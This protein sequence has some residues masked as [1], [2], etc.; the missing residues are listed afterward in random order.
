M[1]SIQLNHLSTVRLS[2]AEISDF[3]PKS[4]RL[5]VTA[6]NALEVVDVS[7]PNNPIKVDLPI[8][9]SSFGAGIQSVAV[10]K[11]TGTENSIVAVAISAN[12]S[13]DPGKVVFFDAVTLAKISE[14][15]VGSLPDMITF[16][17]DGTK[18]LVANEGEPSE[19]YTIDPESS[20]SIIDVSGDIA[21]LDN[22]KVTTA[23]FT[24]F[25]GQIDDLKAN[26]VRIFGPNATVAQDL[27]PEYIAVSP[28]GQT[29]FI[30][31]QENN[32]VAVLDIANAT[33]TDIL[34]LGF[35]DHNLPGN[36]L[37]ASDED[38]GIN[39]QN[40]PVFGM[41]QPDAISSFEVGGNTYYITANEGD[42]RI[43]PT[44]D[45]ILPAPNNEEGD[46]FNEE[47]RIKGV[48][49]DPTAFPNAAELQADENIGRLNITNT[50]GDT[51]GD[52]D[53]DQL[54]TYGA[55][56]FS[57]WNDQGELV[58]D[59]GDQIAQIIA[60]ETPNLFNANDGS[61]DEFDSRSDNK[62]A[63]PESVTV[64]VIDGTPYAFVG[65]E[66]AGGG[67]MVYNLS[68]P[69]APNFVQYIRTEGDVAPE[70]LKF[71]SASDSPNGKPMLA[72]SNEV[73]NTTSFY[74]IV[75]PKLTTFEF[76][77]LPSL[78]TSATGQEFLLGGFS[79]LY[80]TGVAAN[81]NLT[82]VT[83]PDRGP[84]GDNS[85]AG[86]PFPLPDFQPEIVKFEL[87]QTSGEISITD[88]IGLFRADGTTPLTGLPN[89]QPG[90]QGTAY[91]DEFAID[92]QGN[93]VANDPFGA[94]LEGIVVAPN[95]DF[96]MVDEYRP[97]IYH[98]NSDGVLIH[99]FIATGT[100]AAAGQ[101]E[102]TFGTEVLP[103]V[104]AQRRGNRG[105]EAVALEGNKLYA[106]IQSAIDNPDNAG[107]TT[108]RNSRNLRIVELDI[109]SQ[110]VTG[111]YLYLLKD[112]TAS[113]NAKTDKI[114]DAV[115]LGNG[116]FAVVERDDRSDNTSNKLIYQIDLAAATN[117]HDPGNFTLPEG[118]TIE[119]LSPLE[120][121][122]AGITP[123]SKNL[124]INAAQAGYTG[125]EKLEG[126]ALIAPNTLAVLNDNDFNIIGSANNADGSVT[127]NFSET[128]IPEKLGI[129]ELGN[130][131]P[132]A[133]ITGTSE[134]DKLFEF[135]SGYTVLGLAGDDDIDGVLKGTGNN[136][137]D[138]G[139]G[140]D[141][142]YA[143]ENDIALGGSGN[144]YL[145][146]AD[147]DNNTNN[148]LYGGDGNDEIFPNRH[149]RVF[150]DA[151]DDTILSGNGGNT[152]TGGAG[153]DTFW[154]A[155][156]EYLESPNIITD[157]N[158]DEDSLEVNVG[159]FNAISQLTFTLQ[160]NDTLI[161]AND[162]QLA[163]L[164]GQ[165]YQLPSITLAVNPSSVTENG[166]ANLVYT[167]TR[168][169]STTN[170]L[171][172][173][174]GITG[175]AD[176]NDYTGA[177]PGASKTIT[178]EV[179]SST[180]TLT[181]DPTV[182]TNV[183]GDETVILTLATGTDYTVG[184]TE[185][186]TGTITDEIIPD[187]TPPVITAGQS[188]SY[189]E[190]QAADFTV[191]TVAAT[192]NVGVTGFAISSG[193]DSGFF[194]IDN[195]GVI[196][197]TTAGVAS[198]AN[199]FE[200]T[201][202]SFTLGITATDA[203]GTTSTVTDVIVSVTDVTEIIP[204][205]TAP[206]ITA[207]QTFSYAE[208]QAADF[209]V[210]TV[211]ATDNV[212]VTGFAIAS[213]NDSGLFSIDN[214]GV[215]SLTTAGV[216][217]A[218][219]DFETTPNSFTL[220]VTATDAA[221]TTSTVTDVIVSVTDVN[222]IVPDTTAPVITAGQSFS[223]AENQAA[224]F[225]V[226]TVA[227]TDNVGVTGFAIASG[228][229]SGFFSIDNSGVISLTTAGVASA[230][231]DFETTPNSFTL[232]ITATDAAG[233]TSTVTDVIVS[234]TDVNETVP[235]TT[236]P[237]ITAGQSF[238][239]AENQAADFTV[240]TV[241]A[242]DNVGV[243]GFAIASGNDS[244]LFS[245]DNS[246]VISLTTAGV[247]SAANDFETTPN[248]FTLGVTATDAAGTTST[249]TDVIV[250][251]TDVNET[252]PDTTA[253]VIT[254][255][256]SFSY[257]EN[258]AAD[259]TVGTVAA[260]DNVGVTGFAIASGNDLGLFSIDNSGVISLTTAGVASAAN[261]F[262]TT[263]N[264]FTLGVTATDAAGTNSTVTDVIVS[265]TD[266]NED[267]N[268][269]NNPTL[270]NFTQG[271]QEDETI[272][273]G[274]GDFTDVNKGKFQDQDNDD[275]TAIKVTSLPTSGSLTFVGGQPVT[276]D[277]TIAIDELSQLQYIPVLN[278]NGEVTTF[279]VVAID[280]QGG[281]SAPA[282]VTINLTAVNDAPLAVADQL[283]VSQGGSGR[284]NPLSNDSDPD[285]DNL[286]ITNQTNGKYGQVAKNGNNL[287]Y[288]LLDANFIGTDVFSYTVSDGAL[289]ATTNVAV[290][291]TGK[292]AP[293]TVPPYQL[294]SV[295]PG[296]ALIPN[297]ASNRLT[298]I[299]DILAYRFSNYEQ[300]A[301]QRALQNA[302]NRTNAS[303]NNVFGLYEL[304][305]ETGAVN[306]IKPGQAGYA[307]AAL[308]KVVDNFSARVGGSGNG[309][310]SNVIISGD[311]IYAPFVIANSSSLSGSLQQAIN[312]FFA[313]NPNNNRAT[314]QNYTSLTVAYFSFG[315]ANPDG[316]AHLKSFGNNV[317]GFED[318]PAGV[319]VSDYDFND[320]MFSFGG[321]A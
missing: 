235:D 163:I 107:D 82:F 228:N 176:A 130:N 288:T 196:S 299:V 290:T 201:P 133:T 261:D 85:T 21:S 161:S 123:V 33:I 106:F 3:D 137:L 40:W 183:E 205:T 53:F 19:D 142:I 266:V 252:V 26:G 251:V 164:Q 93:A 173:N 62:G 65:L 257:A 188:F 277:Q 147:Q 39:I 307:Q 293:G 208:N 51:D 99:R 181:I 270:E 269:N 71:I 276:V 100:A 122:I 52:G 204:D 275:L 260:T 237:V 92:S 158:P 244:G 172:V 259:F 206:V 262:E 44:D 258:Q 132:V 156:G 120:L 103:E 23:D 41:Y 308:S 54:Y 230:A 233:T 279:D 146:S 247:A 131:L 314:A 253:P 254:A 11:G 145:Q 238:S 73:S 209:T 203:A 187:T 229:D 294:V 59:S 38:G 191:G 225:T 315:A 175:T 135:T 200:T 281:E 6:G 50:L 29:A 129:I 10:R 236:A 5:F 127:I 194:S 310:A 197:L 169:G 136:V 221:G 81:G 186:V 319:G 214:S 166:E 95:G 302:I 198:A 190:N 311:S 305:D 263:P 68:D 108:S 20:V 248:S 295:N 15:T 91:T 13:T 94:D 318:L 87:N 212:G 179:D 218:A 155:N 199:D 282:T 66:R 223:Y 231:N 67:V 185:S 30:T 8:N 152:L 69:T 321:I 256:Q 118:K 182:D 148:T 80:L 2:G 268:T 232:G 4:Q 243:T 34:P 284:I 234:V 121:T 283:S 153:K 216:A 74:E 298:D 18:L 86:R 250:S 316:A 278:A 274:V 195:S 226:G 56:S 57:I 157:F 75:Q 24:A 128:P 151:G 144:D 139:D 116:K 55:R 60:E 111:E 49:L 105:F 113:G 211:V 112:I 184:T 88:R 89:L 97:A 77:N 272:S 273:F 58:F 7:N 165:N 1:N 70:G 154:L 28:D 104:Y 35:K 61:A 215:I 140:N 227:A 125:V 224:D 171:T 313:A 303:F 134:T 309:T 245:I 64:G 291:V 297:E 287:T 213:G 220:G 83:H 210:G 150:G 207:N 289:Q 217:S 306:G 170:P 301:V 241:A 312:A 265:V 36:G 101:P 189:A 143:K 27:E 14:V 17:P 168:T 22:T 286:T 98:F 292:A 48:T 219:N 114:G 25:N 296:N 42:A 167:F 178:F 264:S 126:L 174:Y 149:D 240:G 239:Y 160:G 110:Q 320:A 46:I 271:G 32:A 180:A 117:I 242:T 267:N 37:D 177:T 102:G 79:G 222:E 317:F 45:D 300:S 31:L 249:V 159:G 304:D 12:V 119:Q 285:G 84:N 76:Q 255:G 115:S 246:G 193:N 192:D 96:W 280:S 63:E 162:Q 90:D 124:I 138:G 78:G 16:T 109:N 47:S 141:K 72:I 9:L 202:N 43:R